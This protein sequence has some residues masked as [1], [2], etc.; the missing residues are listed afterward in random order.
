MKFTF[1]NL[2]YL[3]RYCHFMGWSESH[4][5]KPEDAEVMFVLD[6]NRR[7]IA[8]FESVFDDHDEFVGFVVDEHHPNAHTLEGLR[9]EW[10]VDGCQLKEF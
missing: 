8:Q 5:T 2:E 3:Y 7:V 10:L 6:T 1:D 9:E 4:M